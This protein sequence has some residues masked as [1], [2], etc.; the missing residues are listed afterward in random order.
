MSKDQL[1][2][3]DLAGLFLC[4][5]IG[6]V[7]LVSGFLLVGLGLILGA[8]GFGISYG[9]QSGRLGYFEWHGRLAVVAAVAFLVVLIGGV[10]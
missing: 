3:L 9:I 2:S 6:L 10:L 5:A 8:V 7:M 4:L 1:E